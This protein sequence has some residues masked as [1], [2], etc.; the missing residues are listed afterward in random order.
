MFEYSLPDA[1]LGPATETSVRVIPVAEA[2][3]KIAPWRATAISPQ[4]LLHKQ[5]IDFGIGANKR[6]I[7]ERWRASTTV[8]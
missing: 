7:G 8:S 4:H 3:G 6:P 5:A 2:F 1:G